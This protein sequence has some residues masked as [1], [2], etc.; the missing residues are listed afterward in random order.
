MGNLFLCHTTLAV[1]IFFLIS[2]LN[3]LFTILKPFP[4][5]LSPPAL[6]KSLSLAFL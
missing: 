4:L 1:K 2:S 3:L 5:E 6:I